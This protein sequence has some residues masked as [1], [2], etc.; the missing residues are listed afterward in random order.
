M[1]K[2]NN[3]PIEY[4]IGVVRFPIV[5]DAKQFAGNVQN[6]IDD[7]Y[8]HGAELNLPQIAVQIDENGVQVQQEDVAV[9]QFQSTDRNWAVFVNKG[10]I[11]L[12]TRAYDTHEDFI[13]RL[14]R[15]VKAAAS[16]EGRHLRFVEAIALRYLDLIVPLDGETVEHY[17]NPAVV[18][19]AV[20]LPGF[21]SRESIQSFVLEQDGSRM[22]A[23]VARSPQA[24]VPPDLAS[25]LLQQNEWQIPRPE[26]DFA[27]IDVDHARTYPR[28][29]ELKGINIEA[30]LFSLRQPVR[31][32]FDRIATAHA[33]E[34]WSGEK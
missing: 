5:I 26:R 17:I 22:R 25:P 21:E 15:V 24:V 23:Q 28:G 4:V 8:P 2:M 16:V 12:H 11:G 19:T 14:L 10:L 32:I 20:Q 31:D 29:T 1:A 6:L 13:A 18:A 7:D 33:L 27:T 34:V 30:D 9:W 3:A